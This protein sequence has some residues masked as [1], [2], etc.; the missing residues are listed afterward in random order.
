MCQFC[1]ALT[2]EEQTREQD[3]AKEGA[4]GAVG[5]ASADVAPNI[6]AIYTAMMDAPGEQ[7]ARLALILEDPGSTQNLTTY[8]L[9][10]TCTSRQF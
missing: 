4:L 6:L 3:G 10:D 9:A 1:R 2:A 5:Q 8:E 7:V